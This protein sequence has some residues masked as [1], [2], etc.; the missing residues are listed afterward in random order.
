[1]VN[2]RSRTN[3]NFFQNLG[4]HFQLLCICNFF[5]LLV[6]VQREEGF[7]VDLDDYLMGLLQLAGELVSVHV[8]VKDCEIHCT[9]AKF[10]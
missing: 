8:A 9:V 2:F 7:H 10:S 5:Y 3:K 1:M 6:K 4:I